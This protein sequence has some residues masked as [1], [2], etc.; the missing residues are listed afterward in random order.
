MTWGTACTPTWACRFPSAA[1]GRIRARPP[2]AHAPRFPGHRDSPRTNSAAAVFYHPS[3]D[4]VLEPLTPF[5]GIDGTE[6][7]PVLLWDLLRDS[8]EDYM[9][10]FGRPEQVTAWRQGRPYVAPLAENY[11]AL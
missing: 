11:A 5:I 3:L 1:H 9:K 4:T 7:E 10:V 6:Y 8:V 2:R